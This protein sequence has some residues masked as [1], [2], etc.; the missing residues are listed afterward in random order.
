MLRTR[1]APTP[2]GYLHIGNAVNFVLT[3]LW[4]RH[5]NGIVRL[6]I[7]DLDAP[8]IREEYLTDIFETLQWL[9]ID[10]DE[11][12][13]SVEDHRKH[14]SQH[15]RN[16][17]YKTLLQKLIA[18]GKVFACNCSRKNLKE[19]GNCSCYQKHLPLDTEDCALRILTP[20]STMVV[21]DK[22][23]GNLNIGLQNDM[24]NF[25]VRRKDGVAAYQL[26]S[27]ADDLLY[28][29]NLIV[30]GQDLLNST[31]AQLYL[32]Q[33]TDS[34]SFSQCQFYHHPLVKDAEGIKLSKSS[35]G[36]AIKTMRAQGYSAVQF[37]HYLSGLLGCG[38]MAS[39]LN[40][41]LAEAKN[42][43]SLFIRQGRLL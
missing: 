13:K 43:G 10:W 26:A 34:S 39:S 16:A 21:K 5:D 11:G 36:T 8:R 7:D 1:I 4:A 42:G 28:N 12:P 6:R 23:Q 25:V 24:H 22:A 2:S 18:G 31:A 15:L 27:L 41:L 9:G 20:D 14:F 35:G 32:A 30:R 33:L 40:E 17:Q 37:Y 19:A 3:W 29:I 38:I